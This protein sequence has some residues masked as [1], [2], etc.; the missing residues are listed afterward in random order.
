MPGMNCIKIGLPSVRENVFGKSYSLE[1]SLQE[2][3]FRE[4]LFY[5]IASRFPFLAQRQQNT[6]FHLIANRH[7]FLDMYLKFLECFPE[8]AHLVD[9][10]EYVRMSTDHILKVGGGSF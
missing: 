6:L 9:I 7:K 10:F 2:S 1:N 8:E 4:D 3:I 5:T